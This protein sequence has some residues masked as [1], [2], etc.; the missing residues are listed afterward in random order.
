M[1]LGNRRPRAASTGKR[2]GERHFRPA[3]D[4]LED[5]VLLSSI[6]LGGNTV[7][8]LPQIA[9]RIIGMDFAGTNV[10]PATGGGALQQGAGFSVA[11]I[12]TVNSNPYDDF[13]IGAPT[14]VLGSPGTLGSLPGNAVYLVFGSQTVGSTAITD[15][16]AQTS[17]TP[18]TFKYTPNDRVGNLAQL[19]LPSPT[20]TNPITNTALDFPFPGVT[21]FTGTNVNSDLGASVAGLTV[22]GQGAILLGAPGAPDVNGNNPGTGRAYLLWGNFQAQ[23]GKAVNLEDPNFA[24]D[25]PGLNLVTFVNG[26]GSAGGG[27]GSSVAG[28]SNILG[29][30][31]SDV[32]LGAPLAS[33]GTAPV[34]AGAAYVLSTL[35][36]TAGTTLN[37][38]T[39]GT[40]PSNNQVIFTGANTAGT[41][42]ADGG[43]VNGVTSLVHDLLIGAPSADG[44]GA[45]YLIYGT[46]SFGSLETLTNGV[47]SVN[48]TRVGVAGQVPGAVF[49]GMPSGS[50]TGFAVSSAGNFNGATNGTTPIDGILI[51]SPGTTIAAGVN[52]GQVNMFYGATSTS[53]NFLTGTYTLLPGATTTGPPN[54]VLTGANAGDMAGYALSNTG[55]INP[56]APTILIG[57]PGFNGS[58]GTA[59]LIPARTGY[60]GA[61]SLSQISSTTTAPLVGLQFTLTNGTTAN[62]FGASLSS[63]LQGSQAN[64]ADG[65]NL[66]D[67]IVGA[68]GYDVTQTTGLTQ[69]GAGL[70]VEGGLIPGGV[71]IPAAAS[72]TTNIGVGTPF[73]PFSINATTPA[74]LQIFV[75]G[76][77]STTPNFMPVTDINPAT[78]VVNGVAFPNATIQ[79]DPNT[80]NYIPNGIPDA[81]I[82]I[83]PR[84]ALNLQQGTTTITIS[85]STLATSP[86]PG[87]TWTGSA[88]PVTITGGS[89]SPV[90]AGV[91]GLAPGPVTETTFNSAFGNTQFVPTLTQLSIY[92]YQP[93]PVDIALNQFLAA[94]GFRDRSY[95][96]NHPGK[97]LNVDFQSRG[98]PIGRVGGFNQLRKTVFD[99]GAFHPQKLYT[100]KHKPYKYGLLHGVVPVQ[101]T[102]QRYQDI[103]LTGG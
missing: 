95:S 33:I 35:S 20:Q 62:F 80:N 9:N 24:T 82:T 38:S 77:T 71:P 83:S 41:S 74:N 45:A 58:A 59:Y 70:V 17:T 67:F 73:A 37:L 25:F 79:Q 56:N 54:V 28:G 29:D 49:D 64:T 47:F 94:P 1:H 88:T 23:I 27:L 97:H 102:V 55:P 75:F 6:E 81:I 100:W 12:G 4:A 15:W 14:T 18:P 63:R 10:N 44:G 99:R 61:F 87:R 96:F 3:G 90:V 5:K 92:N 16:L 89:V 36:L 40:A 60:S 101:N 53:A 31:A 68:P 98:Q 84:S 13:V 103:Q 42:V 52:T 57:A 8:V 91:T 34:S 11:D 22:N 7:P 69:A 50:K 21:F 48:L 86:L 19:G 76:T 26:A 66:A 43:D 51:G 72:I 85:G 32:I 39:L 65:D 2:S 46:S 30:G 93:L 78:V